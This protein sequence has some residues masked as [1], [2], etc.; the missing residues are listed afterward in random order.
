[1]RERILIYLAM[2]IFVP[3][4][5][6][7]KFFPLEGDLRVSLGTP[8]FFF[9][10]LWSRKIDARLAGFLV[11]ISVVFFRVILELLLTN[12]LQ[13]ETIFILHF[14]VFFYY[15]SFSLL[16]Y[17]CRVKDLYQK[18]L[19]LGVVGALIEIFASTIEIVCSHFFSNDPITFYTFFV[20]GTIAFIRSFFVLGLFNMIILREMK[21]AEEEQRMQNQQMLVHIS[22]L[23][24]EM[25]QL[26]KSMKNTEELTQV[27]YNLYRE[28][29]K[30]DSLKEIA[31]TVLKVAGQVHEIK[32]DHQRIYAGLS[33]L[34]V[35]DHIVDY[36]E[37]EHIIGVV[38]AANERYSNLLGKNIDFR[39]DVAGNHKPYHTF[40]LL[41]ILNNLLANAVEAINENGIIQILV[42]KKDKQ[43]HIQITDNGIGIPKRAK[44]LIFEPGFT[45]KFDSEGNASNGIGLTYI[46]NLIQDLKGSIHLDHLSIE[47]ETRFLIELPIE[48]LIEKG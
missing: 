18:P 44:D 26:K 43:I 24:V 16:F 3:I 31:S 33:K 7:F 28:L 40:I 46:K 41:S 27:C 12:H 35:K 23:Y 38:L 15:L 2:M 25:V 9:F 5:G 37:I 11:S 39:I 34:T 22:H 42:R 21:A 47:H 48:S 32:K 30:Q 10:L 45:T 20:I 14:P 13:L 19:L 17:Y 36:M 8:V 4:G 29:K 1:M 6:E